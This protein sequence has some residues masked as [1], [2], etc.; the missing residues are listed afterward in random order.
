MPFDPCEGELYPHFLR[1][2]MMPAAA[3]AQHIL[4]KARSGL[5]GAAFSLGG[6]PI[7]FEAEPLFESIGRGDVFGAVL[8]KTWYV[9]K[10]AIAPDES[11]L[12]FVPFS[13]AGR[14]WRCGG[15]TR[16]RGANTRSAAEILVLG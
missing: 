4:V 10:P 12:G 2:E 16:V 15:Y 1:F 14:L 11:N 9:S 5:D 3:S 8:S 7:T 6:S 13:N